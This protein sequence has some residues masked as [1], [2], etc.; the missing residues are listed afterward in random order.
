M[1]EVSGWLERMDRAGVS[2]VMQRK[3][4]MQFLSY[5]AKLALVLA[6][7]ITSVYYF[8]RR[9]LLLVFIFNGLLPLI[10]ITFWKI[11][12]EKEKK[13]YWFAVSV[14]VLVVYI[15]ILELRRF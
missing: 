12:R 11:P 13:A 10:V 2:E 7:F 8:H 14:I 15:V 9:E 3:I 6:L 4:D 1:R 5:N